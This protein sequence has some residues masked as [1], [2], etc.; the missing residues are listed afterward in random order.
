MTQSTL[1]GIGVPEQMTGLILL[2]TEAAKETGEAI[3]K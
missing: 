3:R 2:E 1:S